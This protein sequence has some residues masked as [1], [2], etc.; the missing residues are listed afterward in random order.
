MDNESLTFCI[1]LFILYKI[2]MACCMTGVKMLDFIL[3]K[4]SDQISV[5]F[6]GNKDYIVCIRDTLQFLFVFMLS[7]SPLTHEMSNTYYA[8]NKSKIILCDMYS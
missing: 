5:N 3:E 8:I 4:S 6:S 7:F 1:L 2:P